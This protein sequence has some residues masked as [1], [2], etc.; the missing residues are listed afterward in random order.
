[1][2]RKDFELIA[3]VLSTSK[4]GD[5]HPA[6]S[7]EARRTWTYA[8]DE[9]RRTVDRFATMCAAQNPR[10]DRARFLAACGVE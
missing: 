5:I 10:F 6:S 2:T 3:A 7:P 4:I 1:M 9:W 8:R